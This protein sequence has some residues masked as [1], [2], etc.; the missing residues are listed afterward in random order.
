MTRLSAFAQAISPASRHRLP[1]ARRILA[2][3]ATVI[4]A[5]V[6]LT[7][8][9]P[10]VWGGPATYI[11][12]RGTSMLP[13]YQ[14]GDLVLVRRAAQYGPGDIVAYRVPDD[15]V[16]ANMIL[17]HR[18]VDGSPGQGFVLLGDNNEDEDVWNPKD[19]E[20]VGRPLIHISSAGLILT[21]LRSPLVLASLGAGA[22]VAVVAIPKPQSKPVTPARGRHV[23]RGRMW[24]LNLT[25]PHGAHLA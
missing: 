1:R 18:I 11:V 10:T 3:T 15:D 14:P 9:R 13:T 22:A 12:I 6:W 23:R 25:R 17:I 5:A 20:I 7:V 4:V 16:G 2:W 19:S 24:R 21:N 8:L